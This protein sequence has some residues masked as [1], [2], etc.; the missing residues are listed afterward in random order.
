MSEKELEER[1]MLNRKQFLEIR[2]FIQESFPNFKSINQTNYYFDDDKL[3]VKELHNML[4]VR[5]IRGNKIKEFTYKVNGEDGDYEY[6]TPLTHYQYKKLIGD[7]IVPN[8]ITKD[9]LVE[10]SVNIK[11][12]K[13]IVS[14]STKRIEVDAGDYI[15]ALDQNRYNDTTDYNLEI[16]S[17][18]SKNHAK[19]VIN[20]YCSKF[21]LVYKSD[22]KTKVARAFESIKR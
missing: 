22:Y 11:S 10:H 5:V 17:K 12:I 15:L 9:K 14:L 16:E 6:T 20:D 2:K 4:R 1:V 8:G 7:C 19:Q 3:R 13:M 21:N 18:I